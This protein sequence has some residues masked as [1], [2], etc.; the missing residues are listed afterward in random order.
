MKEEEDPTLA[1]DYN[2][3]IPKVKKASAIKMEEDVLMCNFVPMVR[4]Y[5]KSIYI[6]LQ[7]S[8]TNF[9]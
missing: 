6:N 1:P 4:E 2:Y 8:F 9:F 3:G 5:L 7:N